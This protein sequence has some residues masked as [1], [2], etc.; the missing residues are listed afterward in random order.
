MIPER[1]ASRLPTLLRPLQAALWSAAL[2]ALL[3]P[4]SALLG[5]ATDELTL[6][7][8]MSHPEWLGRAPQAPYWNWDSRTFFFYR[9]QP[10]VDGVDPRQRDLFRQVVDGLNAELVPPSGWGEVD[11][12]AGAFDA[13]RTQRAF[14]RDGDLFVRSLENGSLRQ[15]TRTN[16]RET[17]PFFL[18]DGRL[19]FYRGRDAVFARDLIT[20][21]EEQL[22][23]LR[24]AQEPEEKRSEERQKR[25]YVAREEERLID[26]LRADSER[27]ELRQDRE[28]ARR[29]DP[30]RPDPAWFLG[31][32]KELGA[33]WA[34]P[35]GEWALVTVRRDKGRATQGKMPTYI[36]KSGDVE[37]RDVRP[38][39]GEVKR[40]TDELLL[41][42]RRTSTR[43][44]VDLSELP[45]RSE[46]PLAE[47]K[48]RAKERK[49][50]EESEQS[51]A[52]DPDTEA[53]EEEATQE[54]E[55]GGAEGDQHSD[56]DKKK[57]RAISI[58][59]AGWSSTGDFAVLQAISHDNK[60][61]WI[62]AVFPP[63]PETEGSEDAEPS[64]RMLHHQHDEAWIN[65]SFR[66]VDVLRDDRVIYLSEVSGY[67]NL[68][69]VDP[70]VPDAE[71]TALVAGDFLVDDPTPSPDGSAVYYT[72][73]EIHPG[74]TEVYRVA[75]DDPDP[76]RLTDLGGLNEFVLSPD[77][78]RLIV[79]NSQRVRPTELFVAELEGAGA[80]S[81]LRPRQVTD[82]VSPEF[83]D[84]SW[85]APQIVEVPSTHHDRPIYA[86]L[87]LPQDDVGPRPRPAVV[88]VHGA[89][90]LQNAHFGWSGYFREFMF[91]TLLTRRGFVVLDMD[92]RA[93]RGYGRDWRTAIYRQMGT[94]EVEDLEDGVRY[95]AAQHDVD[96][97]RVG[98]YGGSYGGF[99]TFMAMFKE[100]E[101]FAA[102]AALRP[103][104]DWA[105]YNHPYTS[106]ILN[107]PE[108]DPEAYQ[109]SSP[110]EFAE[111]LN[112]PLLI[113]AGMLDDNVF[114]QDS[115]RLVQRLIELGKKDFELAVYPIEPH[116][117][118][119]P[120]S[121]TDEYRRILE[122][123]ETHLLETE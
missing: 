87:Y 74:R 85:V 30:S 101:L 68:Y 24:M 71:S 28:D 49:Q 113:A 12:P 7:R 41:L 63:A 97:D 89:G 100:P 79:Q 78:T 95:L 11:A 112:K 27:Y 60:D 52:S 42:D 18:A 13:A 59:L 9:D 57:P 122:L 83:R 92:Y 50:A 1:I 54:E 94:P 8:I 81:F 21:L 36:A 80:D 46:D 47:L 123:F 91:H 96:S 64:V 33:A 39:V 118:R 31:D 115:V 121:W 22:F 2:S 98:V 19:G 111:G 82:T 51:G 55:G 53:P 37:V 14:Q 15:L 120:S 119:E 34:S 66:D 45:T 29:E 73:N 90:Y 102:G 40:P 110:I 35:S 106:N 69:L 65:W 72:A 77:G 75:V 88:F 62:F 44:A 116:G 6:E 114:F 76:V 5:Q 67:S 109:R 3:L 108:I 99:L 117:F 4:T 58:Q 43:Y 61:R 16:D 103:V 25:D 104:T 26:W 32:K 20:G 48:R 70:R 107:T 84:I 38:K 17:R 93:S 23:E 10:L 56:R 105:H 86:R